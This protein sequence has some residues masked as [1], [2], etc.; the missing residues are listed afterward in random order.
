MATVV[1]DRGVADRVLAGGAE[2]RTIFV[3]TR[4]ADAGRPAVQ[5]I[6]AAIRRA[7]EA[8]VDTAAV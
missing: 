4:T 1:R 8:L 5:A 2:H 3:A 6:V 7:A